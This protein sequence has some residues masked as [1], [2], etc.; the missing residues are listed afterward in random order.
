MSYLK[1]IYTA[2]L[3]AYILTSLL[4]PLAAINKIIFVLLVAVYGAYL[5]IVK[6]TKMFDCLKITAAPVIIIAIFAYGLVRGMFNGADMALAKQFFLSVSIFGLIYPIDEFEIDMNKILIVIAKIY[7]IFF[8]IFTI[9]AMNLLEFDIP[10]SIQKIVELLDNRVTRFIGETIEVWGSSKLGYRSNFDGKG[11]EIYIGSISFILVLINILYID[12]FQTRKYRNFIYILLGV[13]LS[14]VPGQRALL[15]LLPISLCVITWIHM[16]RKIQITAL[17]AFLVLGVAAF[18]YLLNHSNF[19]DLQNSSNSIKIG[20]IVSYFEQFNLKQAIW[21]DGLATYYY[22]NYAPGAKDFLVQTE[23]TMLDH[24]RYFGIP[25][26]IVV[27][28]SMVFPRWSDVS[29]G[30]KNLSIW[31]IKE[32]VSVLLLY[33]VWAQLNPVLFNSFGL[34]VVL[35]YWNVL[36]RKTKKEKTI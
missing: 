21:G 14:L 11:M 6:K 4:V 20:H 26:T 32:E 30:W 9:Y 36:L 23:V 19:F 24:F 12:F 8:A 22:T 31:K 2:M 29:G 13:A 17:G 18:F 10:E 33:F 34:I 25:L 15:L 35:W 5:L 28:I 7:I 27:W 1:K 16:N 3:V